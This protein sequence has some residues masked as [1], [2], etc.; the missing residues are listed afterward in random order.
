MKRT[1]SNLA[2]MASADHRILRKPED[3][4]Q[5]APGPETRP[6]L[7]QLESSPETA[8]VLFHDDVRASAENSR[9]FALAL[10]DL[11][12]LKTSNSLRRGLAQHALPRLIASV[13]AWPDD[14]A[15]WQGQGYAL[16]L[17]DR[18]SEALTA[19]ETALTLA[20][21][22]EEALVYAAAIAAQLGRTESA[23][24]YWQR[25]IQVNPWSPRSHYELAKLLSQ[26]HQWSKAL[27]EAEE[28]RALNPF[29]LETRLLLINCYLAQGEKERARAEFDEL[30]RFNPANAVD[31]RG[32]FDQ[33][34]R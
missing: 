27:S 5:A 34:V 20:P 11:A 9:D 26:S 31:L 7:T 13:Q 6:W 30:L 25:A 12:G 22:R 15:A 21:R 17:L 24:E 32:W 23:L 3:A 19:L 4:K 2:H 29:H 18:K 8:L 28:A 10:M 33:A 16:W 14:V 1:N